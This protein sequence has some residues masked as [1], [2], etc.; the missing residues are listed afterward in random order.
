MLFFF[1]QLNFSE[2]FA[3]TVNF[4][5]NP[6]NKTGYTLAIQNVIIKFPVLKN[7]VDEK[8][9]KNPHYLKPTMHRCVHRCEVSVESS[10]AYFEFEMMFEES[11]QSYGHWFESCLNLPSRPRWKLCCTPLQYCY[12][13]YN[14]CFCQL[15]KKAR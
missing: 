8:D 3:T 2:Y 15:S 12:N 10:S 1:S 9:P 4:D 5:W 14:F 7:F 13:R 6:N 11:H